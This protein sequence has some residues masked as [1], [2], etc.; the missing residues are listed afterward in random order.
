MN[1]LPNYT[2]VWRGAFQWLRALWSPWLCTPWWPADT[3][4]AKQRSLVRMLSAAAEEHLEAAPLVACLSREH[5]GRYRRRLRRLAHRLATG[6]SLADAV[7]QTPGALSDEEVLAVRFGD[8]SGT[9]SATLSNLLDTRNQATARIAARLRQMTFYS[10]VVLTMYIL[11]LTFL[12]IKIIPSFN[13]IFNDFELETPKPLQLLVFLS[14]MAV[15]YFYVILLVLL[16]LAWLF[17]SETSHRFFRRKIWSRIMP[18][19]AQLRAADLLDLLSVTVQSGRPLTG[20]LST[21]ARYHFDTYIRHKLLFVRNEVEQGAKVW[22]AMAIVRLLTPAESTALECST[23]PE[24][25][26][27][28]LRQLAQLKR[29][30]VA[31]RIDLGVNLLQPLVILLLAGLVLFVAVACLSPLFNLIGGLSG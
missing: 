26:A 20:S 9:L 30:R 10:T 7:E 11:I 5:R 23:S 25:Q 4:A 22:N 16:G 21:L 14:Q 6:M 28:S 18:P 24:S 8:Q 12:M 19:V 27:W 15:D 3:L 17:R 1:L 13:A 2:G 29:G 31:R